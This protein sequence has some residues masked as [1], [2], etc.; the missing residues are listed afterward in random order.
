[1][2]SLTNEQILESIYRLSFIEQER[3]TKAV[4]MKAFHLT[5]YQISP[6][7]K[8][9][10]TSDLVNYHP[11]REIKLTVQG[12]ELTNCIIQSQRL[13]LTF[14]VND[15]KLPLDIAY[16]DSI[17][18]SYNTSFAVMENL[19][20]NLNYPLADP[21]GWSIGLKDSVEGLIH[22]KQLSVGQKGEVVRLNYSNEAKTGYFARNN[23]KVGTVIEGAIGEEANGEIGIITSKILYVLMSDKMSNAIYLKLV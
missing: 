5:L 2:I 13:W 20:K 3:V 4:L 6:I 22:P 16:P 1:M 19:R 21:L 7:I 10:V 18:L 8:R 11:H 15:L 12:D 14:L 23:I 9:L 17:R